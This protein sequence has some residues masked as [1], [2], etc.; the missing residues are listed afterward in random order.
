MLRRKGYLL[1]GMLIRDSDIPLQFLPVVLMFY[2]L[3]VVSSVWAVCV[4]ERKC[5]EIA[6]FPTLIPIDSFFSMTKT[7]GEASYLCNRFCSQIAPS[8]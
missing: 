8:S 3:R 5:L 1:Q 2:C 4:T 6:Y 7:S